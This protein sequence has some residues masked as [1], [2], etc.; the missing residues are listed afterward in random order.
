VSAILFLGESGG[1]D[2]VMVRREALFGKVLVRCSDALTHPATP[3]VVRRGVACPV[4]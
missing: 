2:D 4:L 3:L 1:G